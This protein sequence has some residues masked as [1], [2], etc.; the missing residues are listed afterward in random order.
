[1]LSIK[2]LHYFKSG[3]AGKS[4]T[5]GK[6]GT[7]GHTTVPP[8]GVIRPLIEKRQRINRTVNQ[9]SRGPPTNGRKMASESVTFLTFSVQFMLKSVISE[10]ACSAH[11]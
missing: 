2:I 9:Q 3:T 5:V 11:S 6:S 7:A 4:G 8:R 10:R 1:M